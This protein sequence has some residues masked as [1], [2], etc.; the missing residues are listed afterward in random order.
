MPPSKYGKYITRE[1]IAESKYPEITTPMARYNGCRGGGDAL[2]VEW[3]CLTKPLVMDQEPEVDPERDQFL[4]FGGTN[5]ED[6]A[7][8]QAEI[9]LAIGPKG[10]KQ[11]ISEPTVVYLPRG[12]THGPVTV[13]S[14]KKPIFC[15]S[16]HLAPKY[17]ASWEAPTESDY[18]ANILKKTTSLLDRSD[19]EN[20]AKQKRKPDVTIIHQPED[21][22]RYA[23]LPWGKGLGYM[24][25]S[26][27]MGFPAQTSWSYMTTWYRDYTLFE[28]VHAHRA[29]HQVSL[30]LGG[31]PLDIED[32]G[33]EID[34]F[35]GKEH[36]RHTLDTC[37]VVHYVP[38][39]PHLGNEVR[40]AKKPFMHAMWCIGP[41]M[42]NYYAAAPVDKVLLSDE[43]KGEIMITPGSHD[44]VPPT[45]IEDWVWPYP[46]TDR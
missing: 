34:V 43:A 18:L 36:E 42:N 7:E 30:Y 16:C 14:V 20:E 35:M 44:Y 33:G 32:F 37:G 13:K 45:P 17:S 25:W 3:S 40:S 2:S 46:V 27:D 29:S 9:E 1:I 10:K 4:L 15:L 24:L 19:E 39:I 21:P 22:F 11:L 28:P 31:D 12:L 8:F 5:L 23:Y 6:G 38:G 41:H 26:S